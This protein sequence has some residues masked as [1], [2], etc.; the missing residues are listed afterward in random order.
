MIVIGGNI[1]LNFIYLGPMIFV[2]L[3]TF[4]YVFYVLKNFFKV[5]HKL[6]EFEAHQKAKL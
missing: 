2:S 5:T 4:I 6:T 1:I 3:G